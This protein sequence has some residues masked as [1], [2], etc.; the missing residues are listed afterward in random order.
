[1]SGIAS[2]R[3][4]ERLIISGRVSVDGKVMYDPATDVSEVNQIEF[5]GKPVSP[6]KS[7]AK[8][9]LAFNKPEG[10]L[11]TMIQG[12]EKGEILTDYVQL[13]KR[14]Y[15]VGRLDRES[16]GLLILTDDGDLTHALTH[17]SHRVEKEYVVK[18][19]QGIALRDFE[20]VRK[21]VAVEGRTVEVEKIVSISKL[22][23]SLVIHEGRKRIIRRL[24]RELGYN[25]VE[26]KRIRIGPLKLGKLSPGRWRH[27]KRNEIDELKSMMYSMS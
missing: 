6:V 4:S 25:T 27:L 8:T 23:L 21:G 19:N 14:I 1:M 17:P 3:A 18:L 20:I 22:K 24:F 5:D 15:P 9:Y 2:R 7:S 26:L 10:V 11:S 16:K 13:K 12:R